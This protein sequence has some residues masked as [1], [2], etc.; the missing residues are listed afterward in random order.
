MG[1]ILTDRVKETSITSGTG[2]VTLA[3]AFGGFVSFSAGI[4]NGNTTYYVIENGTNFE[5]GIGTYTEVG[6]TLSRDTVLSSSNSGS[7][8]D[9]SGVSYV[10]CSYPA[11]K[12][13][14]LDEDG[15][16]NISVGLTIASGLEVSNTLD[17]RGDLG[18]SGLLTLK[19]DSAGNFFHAYVD[20]SNDETISLYH[21]GT[22]SPDWKLGLKDSPN[23][24][25]DPPTYAYVYAGDGNIGLYSNSLTSI[26]LTHG[27]G[28]NVAHK[29]NTVFESNSDTGFLATSYTTSQPAFRVKGASAQS[30]NL[31]EW[32]NSSDIVLAKI[33]KDGDL[34]ARTITA[35]GSLFA[36]GH[37]VLTNIENNTTSG[38]AVSGWAKYYTDNQDHSATAVSGALQPQITKNTAD[39]LLVSGLTAVGIDALTHASGDYF[40][41]EIRSNSASGTTNASDLLVVSGIAASTGSALPVAS[42]GKITY[43]LDEIRAN[44]ASGNT[45]ATNITANTSLVHASG[46]FLLGEIVVN[47]ASGNTNSTN[48]TSNTNLIHASGNSL[49]TK[50]IA[51]SDSGIT[52]NTNI[53]NNT[54]SINSSGNMLLD[55]VRANSASGLVISGVASAG[56]GGLP[57]SSGDYFLTEIRSNSASGNSNLTEIRAN[58]A[59]GVTNTNLVH[60]SGDFLLGE[61]TVNSASGA[62][63]S[64]YAQGYAN[65]KVANLIDS[66]PAALDTLNELAAAINDDANISTTLTSLIT[67]NTTEIRANSASGVSNTN[68]VNASGDFLLGE[69][70]TNSASGSS[71][72]TEVRANSASG[73]FN[74]TEIRANSASGAANLTEI[75]ANSASGVT[76]ASAINNSGVFWLG[77][78]QTNSA[79]GA[80]NLTEIRAN[81]ASGNFNLTEIRANSASGA[82]NLTEIRA[83]SASGTVNVNAI[84]ASGDFLLNEI[85]TNSASGNFSAGSGIELH[86]KAF[87]AAVSGANLLATNTPTDNY[88]P[89]YDIATGKF[90]WVENAG[91]GGGGGSM[92]SVKSNGSAVGGSDIVTLDFSSDFGVAETPD[93]EINITIGTLNQN[94]T[95]SA[96]TLTTARAIALAG[97]V[98]GTA[99]FDGSA[100]ISITSTIANDAVTYA[101]M[102]DTSA[103]NRLLGAATAGTIGE[104]QVATAMIADD[105]VTY[106]KMQHTGTANRVLGAASAGA[107]GEVQVA[108]DM[109]ADDAISYAK[110]QNVSATDKILGRD[111][112]GAGVIEEISP[113]SLRTMINVEDGATAD[114]TA[115][116]ILTLLEDGIDSV[117]YKDGSIDHVHLAADCVDGDNIQDD[118]INSE[119]YVDGS[120]DT[121]HIADDQVT[122]AKMAGLT[123]GSIIIGDSSGDPAALAIGSNTYVLTS[124]GT[125]ISWASAGGGSSRSVAGDT[126]NGIITWVTSD[127]TFASEAN[128]T[129]ASDELTLTS[130]SASKPIFH[131]TNT[132]AG[133]TAGELRFNKDSASGDDSDVMG[134]ISFY[135]TDAAEN[136]HERLAYI[137]AIIT[138]SAHT[139]EAASLRFY[140]AENDAN[141]TAGLVLAGQADADGEVD[142]TLGAGAASTTTIA[143]TLTMGSTAA[144]TNAGLV[145]VANQS[146]ITGLG[147]LTALTVDNVSINGTTIGHTSDTDLMTLASAGL[148]LAGSLTVGVD[149]TGHDVKLFGA[150]SGKYLLWDESHDRLTL[151]GNIV[152][153]FHHANDSPK[154]LN[155]SNDDSGATISLDLKQSNLFNVVLTDNTNVTKIEF[156][157]GTRGQKFILRITQVADGETAATV[158]WTD[159]DYNT[160]GGGATVRWAGN[161]IPTMT[162]NTGHTDVYGFLCTNAAG[163]AFDGFIIGQDLPD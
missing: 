72:L 33:D 107:I 157:N 88:V 4:G 125:D 21:D 26:N 61:I 110:I 123:R 58:S 49:L 98:T 78:I 14:F 145:S 6:N 41:D 146:N 94:T 151:V 28:F 5:I 73:N 152:N 3:G 47:S 17:V 79:S 77:E 134:L 75:R 118:V 104:V 10:F 150:T 121:A 87:Q 7:K 119:H 159:V 8:I 127:N 71:N 156:T 149:D 48:I 109:V 102:Q 153:E 92:T 117:H 80:A 35:T 31:Q 93:T 27:G 161:T 16:A 95:G 128:F 91:G 63:I 90:T 57:Y 85:T 142:V 46:D 9:L 67:A 83:N 44:S 74:L 131:I 141:L 133:A 55:E 53:N 103:D 135:G 89:S 43:N 154:A 137:D 130:S 68:L 39:I 160:T 2:S 113:A 45:N 62:S 15:Q 34:S 112:A 37:N 114:Q 136:T 20:D 59:S 64:G 124:D 38:V 50:I 24:S 140:V 138:D 23:N 101:K 66:A 158:A 99:N 65:M 139:S 106:A 1:L 129:Y 42:G 122:L 96:A 82:A 148:T 162:T 51:N 108:T 18:V 132:H 126:D 163:T 76:N 81:S 12:A 69:I 143:G 97:D 30:A 144:L 60:S 19:R 56:G 105:A 84:N 54:L 120:I 11:S 13:V 147:T 116:E 25:G 22:V 155:E 36:S 29:G 111:S 32:T 52:R 70:Q 86:G 40:L 115:G 100:G